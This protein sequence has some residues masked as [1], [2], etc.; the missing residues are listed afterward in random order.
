MD[1]TRRPGLGLLVPAIRLPGDYANVEQFRKLA[2]EGVAGFLLFGG[3]DELVPP[4]LRSLREAAGRPIYVMTDAERGV[5]QQVS[6]C[7]DL[8]PLMAVGATLSEERAYHHGRVTALEARALGINTVL[9]PVMDVLSLPSNPIIGN[10]SFGS[11]ADLVA[12]LGAAWIAGA[13]E[14]GVLACA[15]HFPGHGHTAGDSHAELPTVSAPEEEIRRRELPPFRAAIAAGVGSIMTAHVR[16]PA[17]DPDEPAT[18]SRTILGRLLRDELGFG[19]LVISDALT[20]EGL[21]VAGREGR[22]SEADAA[23]RC[24]EAGCDLLLHPT[25]PYAVAEALE[26]ANALGRIELSS[27]L[28]RILLTLSDL[29]VGGEE[30]PGL[31]AEHLYG[32]YAL[33]RD[34]LTVLSNR[35]RVLPLD[36]TVRR[37]VLAIL[38][39]DDDDPRRET[40]FREHAGDFAGGFVRV[41]HWGGTPAERTLLSA[42]DE[43]D[44]V[45]L[46]I[47]SSIRSYKGRANLDAGLR[48]LVGEVVARAPGRTVTVLFTAPGALEGVDPAPATLV[49]AWGDAPVTLRAAMDVILSGGGLRGLDPTVGH[50]A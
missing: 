31:R 2:A 7:N 24:V 3:D 20:M 35:L 16:Y 17:L 48:T 8:P 49:A 46:G 34:C 25:D 1:R 28:A 13:Q 11:S 15:K 50:S 9:A 4:F 41:A 19:G 43:A 42:V 18:L 26:Q 22:L 12:R 37:K 5:G 40:A 39:D 10:R 21:L 23:V 6:G 45:F 27:V 14:Q 36:P 38:V 32:A 33:A 47:A 30:P 44:V 29:A